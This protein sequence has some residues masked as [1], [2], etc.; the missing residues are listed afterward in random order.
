MPETEKRTERIIFLA[1]AS[2]VRDIEE[3][4]FRERV[5]GGRGAA[6]RELIRRGLR[7]A[8]PEAKRRRE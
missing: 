6:I 1:T 3:F 5:R 7:R 2:E 4:M 8:K